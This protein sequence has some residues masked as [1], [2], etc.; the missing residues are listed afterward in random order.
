MLSMGS[1]SYIISVTREPCTEMVTKIHKMQA[2]QKKKK[3]ISLLLSLIFFIESNTIKLCSINKVYS[4][5][6]KQP[7]KRKMSIKRRTN[8][9]TVILILIIYF[10]LTDGAL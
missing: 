5:K 6:K 10:K 2:L 3:I 1:P 4:C 7:I 9:E 8:I